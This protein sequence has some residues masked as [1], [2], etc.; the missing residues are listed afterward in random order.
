[1][2][3]TAP[4]SSATCSPSS[5]PKPPSRFAPPSPGSAGEQALPSTSRAALTAAAF[6]VLPDPVAHPEPP[7]F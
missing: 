1:M 3:A 7:L 2:M 6:G 4:G 5:A